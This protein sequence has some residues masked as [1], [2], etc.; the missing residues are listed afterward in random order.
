MYF[1]R[2]TFFREKNCSIRFHS[3]KKKKKQQH[4]Q[5]FIIN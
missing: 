2:L 1:R 3:K 4:F 5:I